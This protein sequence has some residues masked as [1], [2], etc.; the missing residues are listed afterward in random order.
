MYIHGIHVYYSIGRTGYA[1]MI[2]VEGKMEDKSNTRLDM[3]TCTCISIYISTYWLSIWIVVFMCM[4]MQMQTLIHYVGSCI[5]T[6]H[7]HADGHRQH[8]LHHNHVT[9]EYGDGGGLAS[10]IVTQEGGDL[11]LIHV[12]L[13]LIHCHL[14][15]LF[16][17]SLV[18]TSLY[19]IYEW[20][21]ICT[22]III[23][24]YVWV[25]GKSVQSMKTMWDKERVKM[26]MYST[27]FLLTWTDSLTTCT[28]FCQVG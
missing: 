18:T 25:Q 1:L 6:Y 4:R 10:S 26:Y 22:Y 5:H 9:S 27:W 11:T 2:S 21:I 19:I 8:W 13:Q 28:F 3:Y 15:S 20:K 14:P 12:Q 24:T 16:S 23:C 7:V 17:I